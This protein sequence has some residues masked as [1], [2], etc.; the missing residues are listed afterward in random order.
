LKRDEQIHLRA[1]QKYAEELIRFATLLKQEIQ[2]ARGE[3]FGFRE[4]HRLKSVLDDYERLRSWIS[5]IEK[6]NNI[7]WMISSIPKI[8]FIVVA[9]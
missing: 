3:I 4:V 9:H 7:K 2:N 8:F 6:L 1:I 5:G